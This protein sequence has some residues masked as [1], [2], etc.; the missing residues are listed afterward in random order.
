MALASSLLLAG[1]LPFQDPLEAASNLA[2]S[3]GFTKQIIHT[4]QYDILTYHRGLGQLKRSLG[5]SPEKPLVVYIE[6]DG[7]AFKR[8][9]KI[10]DDPSPHNPLALKLAAADPSPAVLYIARPC[11]FTGGLKARGCDYTSWSSHR[12][13]ESVVDSINQVVSDYVRRSAKPPIILVGYSGGGAVATLIAGRRNDVKQLVTIAGNLDHAAWTEHH[14]LTALRGSLNAIGNARKLS[15]L[16]QLHLAGENDGVVP[17]DII[18]GYVSRSASPDT[19]RMTVVP[20]YDHHCC[21]EESW[22]ALLCRNG[23]SHHPTC[24]NNQ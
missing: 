13:S 2:S 7:H 11:Q 14:Q 19:V 17:P 20:G 5:R 23:A 8:R 18:K 4:S 22:P 24:R 10:S 9:H 16:P 15:Q 6:G 3:S 21:W 1:C 12:Y